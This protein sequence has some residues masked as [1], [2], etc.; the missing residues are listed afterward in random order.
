M[1]ILLPA[2]T[3]CL[4]LG[5]APIRAEEA[6]IG[7]KLT[8]ILTHALGFL[9]PAAGAPVQ[10]LRLSGSMET[11]TGA[12]EDLKGATFDLQMQPPHYLKLEITAAGHAVTLCQNGPQWWI[13]VPEKKLLVIGDPTVPRFSTRPDSVQPPSLDL[14]RLPINRT[15]LMMVP[16]LLTAATATPADGNKAF[17]LSL[18]PAAAALELPVKHPSLTAIVAADSPSPRTIHYKDDANTFTLQLAPPKTSDGLPAS[19]WE[20]VPEAG[21]QVEKVALAHLERFFKS[22]AGSLGS[23]LPTLPPATGQRWL[24]GTSGA[25]RLEDHDGTRVLF[26]TGT[27]E[28]MGRQ[29]GTLLKKE[30]R[31]VV[32]RI[33]YGVGVGSSFDKGRWF[34]GEI[35][36]AVR[37]TGPFIDPR[38]L[39]E[40]D[41]LAAAAGLDS[42]EVRLANFFPELFH[43][44]GFALL[45][46]AT[47]GGHLYHGRVLD[48]LRGVGLEENAVVIVSRPDRGHAWV[49]ISYAGFTGSVTAMNEKQLCLGEMGGKG[50]GS[51]DGKPMAQL[52]REVMEQCSTIEEGLDFMRRTP[53]TCEYYYVL[54]DAKSQRAC[55]IKA[56]PEI[57]EVIWSGESHPQLKDAVPDTVLLSAGS[58]YEELVRRVKDGFGNFDAPKAIQLMTRPVCMTSNIH[59]VL[60][61]PDTLDFWV[62]NADSVSPASETRFTAYNLR[63]LLQAAPATARP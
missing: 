13:K 52:V 6:P 39:A 38:H 4:T 37:R 53:R 7:Q 20:P 59:S 55:G 43:C 61:A 56:T 60:F 9:Q 44:S 34:F 19:T 5:T 50:E 33:L 41:A 57:F 42:E 17:T 3:L 18:S 22:A 47:S 27:P 35:E 30:I 21:H 31:R 1:K 14:Y 51:W 25:G 28:E 36:E 2:V 45:G 62:A 15:Q 11:A 58:R 10:S 23:R 24:L 40:M 49:N 46:T 54:S 48:Y 8:S 63:S 26:L 32:E 29:H 12:L 16:A